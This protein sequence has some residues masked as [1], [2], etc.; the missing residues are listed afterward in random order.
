MNTFLDLVANLNHGLPFDI[1]NVAVKL[2]SGQ[3]L[4]VFNLTGGDRPTNYD[5]T[6]WLHFQN[7]ELEIIIVNLDRNGSTGMNRTT[8]DVIKIVTT[9]CIASRNFF[10]PVNASQKSFTS[11][12]GIPTKMV[13]T[14]PDS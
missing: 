13:R 11:K 10:G 8:F 1:L 3:P 4:S 6:I 9:H 12:M 7:F 5:I 14:L 2:I